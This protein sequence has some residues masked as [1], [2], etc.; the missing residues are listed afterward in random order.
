ML[1]PEKNIFK[2]DE[3]NMFKPIDEASMFKPSADVSA[4]KP[5]FHS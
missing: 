2:I 1:K 5:S 3:T 4:T